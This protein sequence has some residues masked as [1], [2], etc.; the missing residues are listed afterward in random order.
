M[1]SPNIASP[2]AP[3]R[4]YSPNM[5]VWGAPEPKLKG[6]ARAAPSPAELLAAAAGPPQCDGEPPPLPA[7]APAALPNANDAIAAL[8]GGA[9]SP[10]ACLE[11]NEKRPLVG[12][13]TAA[14]AAPSASVALLGAAAFSPAPSPKPNVVCLPLKLNGPPGW[15]GGKTKHLEEGVPPCAGAQRGEGRGRWRGVL[16]GG[17]ACVE[18]GK[19]SVK[20]RGG[21]HLRRMQGRRL[22]QTLHPG[23]WGR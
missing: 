2:P 23:C 10:S 17:G 13:A 22:A 16:R 15:Q 3:A 14:S 19:G 1:Y 21:P 5:N 20:S 18:T 8:L 4:T 7:A 12:G 6:A 11:P 9:L